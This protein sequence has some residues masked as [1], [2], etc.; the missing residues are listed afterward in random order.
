MMRGL[1]VS[2]L[3]LTLAAG[4]I[5]AV[6]PVEVQVAGAVMAAPAELREGAAV[7]GYSPSGER[8]MLRQG[9]NEMFCLA[10]DPGRENFNVACYHKDLDPFMAR[11][12]ELTAQ[13]ITGEK[14]NEIRYEEIKAGKLKMPTG[15]RML[16]VLTGARFDAATGTLENPYLRWVIYA[17]YATAATTGFST[18]P[19]EG[20]PWLM[21]EGSPGAHI[22]ISPPRK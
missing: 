9:S 13:K 22:M 14:R 21:L 17:P 20:A 11:G 2:F 15:M 8:V 3:S 18:K 10:D 6:P 12:R 5:A 4:A 1:R 16:Y 19:A 7:L